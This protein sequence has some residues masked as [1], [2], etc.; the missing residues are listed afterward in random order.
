MTKL[1]RREDDT[2]RCYALLSV[3]GDDLTPEEVR[4]LRPLMRST[5]TETWHALGNTVGEDAWQLSRRIQAIAGCSAGYGYGWE[6]MGRYIERALYRRARVRGLP[7][8]TGPAERF[9]CR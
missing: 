4:T 3:I 1:Y 5:W 7:F 6:S 9:V 8:V 2:C